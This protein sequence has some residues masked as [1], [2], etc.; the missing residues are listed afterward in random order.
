M[1]TL[2]LHHKK[3]GYTISCFRVSATLQTVFIYQKRK[4]TNSLNGANLFFFFSWRIHIYIVCIL[5]LLLAD[6]SLSIHNKASTLS[7]MFTGFANNNIGKAIFIR[8]V[9]LLVQASF[10]NKNGP[11]SY[12]LTR[13]GMSYKY[14]KKFVVL[15]K[16]QTNA[17][18]GI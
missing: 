12:N 8:P 15:L 18:E 3:I 11:N 6:F 9:Y 2:S 13:G 5:L 7:F 17:T 10:F 14:M 4:I 1:P 16:A